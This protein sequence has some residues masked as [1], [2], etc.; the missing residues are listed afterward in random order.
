MQPVGTPQ[1]LRRDIQYGQQVLRLAHCVSGIYLHSARRSIGVASSGRSTSCSPQLLAHDTNTRTRTPAR[2]TRAHH[3]ASRL[4]MV[5]RDR[6]RACG[7]PPVVGAHGEGSCGRAS[8]NLLFKSRQRSPSEL[9]RLLRELSMRLG[10][11]VTVDGSWFLADVP[12]SSESRRKVRPL[13]HTGS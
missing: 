3:R 2:T 1:N 9:V 6:P 4:S 11:S 7:A 5:E 12:Q 8:M 13:A 10:A